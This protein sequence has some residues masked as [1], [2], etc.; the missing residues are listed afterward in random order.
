MPAPAKFQKREPAKV[1]PLAIAELTE[2]KAYLSQ[3]SAETLAWP[4]SLN[5]EFAGLRDRY[6]RGELTREQV[7]AE[8]RAQGVSMSLEYPGQTPQLFTLPDAGSSE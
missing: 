4:G 5:E 8:I 7:L 1:L 2:V 3:L 6:A